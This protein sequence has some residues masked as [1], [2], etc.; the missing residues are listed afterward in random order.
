MITIV[1]PFYRYLNGKINA[2]RRRNKPDNNKKLLLWKQDVLGSNLIALDI[3]KRKLLYIN[4][5]NDKSACLMIDLKDVHNCFTKK[6]YYGIAAGGL[7]H[8]KLQDYLKSILL[9]FSFKNSNPPIAISFYEKERNKNEEGESLEM[10][11]KEWEATISKL[12]TK[13]IAERA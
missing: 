5:V 1:A 9:Q 13:Q 12:L 7:M 10:K 8:N 3:T 4:Q 11:A 2:L 6:Q